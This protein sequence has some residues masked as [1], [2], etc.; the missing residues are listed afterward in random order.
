[1]T[2][3]GSDSIIRLSICCLARQKMALFA[4]VEMEGG[5]AH[6]H[7]KLNPG[8]GSATFA[9]VAAVKHEYT[10]AVHIHKRF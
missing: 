1:E 8:C 3:G 6:K 9:P 2:R 4:A 10:S 5:R 7:E